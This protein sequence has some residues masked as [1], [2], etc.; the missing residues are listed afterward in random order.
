MEGKHKALFVCVIAE[1]E[2]FFFSYVDVF[3]FGDE[4]SIREYG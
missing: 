1:L 2:A 3:P 4:G